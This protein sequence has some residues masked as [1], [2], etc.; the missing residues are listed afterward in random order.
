M[1]KRECCGVGDLVQL[2]L[3]FIFIIII[4]SG[5]LFIL[6]IFFLN[7]SLFYSRRC[8]IQCLYWEKSKFLWRIPLSEKFN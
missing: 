2:M 7:Y 8:Y 5:P 1:I 4:V 3:I 6:I